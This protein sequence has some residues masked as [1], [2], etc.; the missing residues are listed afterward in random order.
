MDILIKPKKT[1][2]GTFKP[3]NKFGTGRP[4]GS[5]TKSK[6]YLDVIGEQNM[7]DI[8]AVVVQQ[9]KNGDVAASRLLIERTHYF[10]KG[11][12]IKL[13]PYNLSTLEGIG[14][15]CDD[16][17]DRMINAEI[18]PAE[19]LEILEHFDIRR[20]LI[21]TNELQVMVEDLKHKLEVIENANKL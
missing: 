13:N 12:L 9:A 3:G 7:E 15:A 20:K 2:A 19:S 16:I 11:R 18:S 14:I 6:T 8:V 1:H 10:G 5:R 17:C 4:K 21:E